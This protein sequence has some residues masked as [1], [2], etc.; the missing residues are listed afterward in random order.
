MK[1]ASPQNEKKKR[2]VLLLRRAQPLPRSLLILP[3]FGRLEIN[4]L[5]LN[6]KGESE[7]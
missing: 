1:K 3:S 7:L 5:G 2:N 4:P 6:P